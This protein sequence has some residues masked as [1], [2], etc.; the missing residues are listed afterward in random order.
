MVYHSYLTVAV[1]ALVAFVVTVVGTLFIKSYMRDAGVT[2]IDHNKKGRPV[3]ASGGGVAVA[4]GFTVGILTYVFGSSFS[5]YAPASSLTYLFA[6]VIAVSLISFVGFIDD[7]NV[8]REMVKTTDM[9]DTRKGLKQW[10]KPLLTLIGAIPLMA[11]NAGVSVVNIPLLGAV[12]FGLFYPLIIIPL[13]VI[14]A[15]NAFNLLGGFDGI[16]TGTGLIAAA[17]LLLYSLIYGT[18]IG[19]IMSGVLFATL[20]AFFFF[21]VYPA[22]IIPGDSYTYAVGTALVTIMILGSAEAF[23]L[24]IFMPWI[25]EFLLHLKKKFHTTD[26]G[27]LNKDGTFTAPY[28]KRISSWTHLIMNSRP[29]KEWQVSATM[30]GIEIAFVALAFAMKALRLA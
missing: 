30:W 3:L 8:K 11:V 10:Q 27:K 17:A 4:F 5:F 13:A 24:I 29:M 14:F 7:I 16:A 2:A 9:M 22:S 28:G 26:L 6:T 20:L 1:P 12:N 25:I 19:S 18:Y 21:N 15:S 23:G